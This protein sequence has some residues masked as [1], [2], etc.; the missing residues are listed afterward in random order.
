MN[1]LLVEDER[2]QRV[3]LAS[4]IKSNFIDVRIY[5]AASQA[6]AIK[7]INE[8]DIH[9]FFIDIQ[10]KDSSGLELA[11]KNKAIQATCFNWNRICNRRAYTHYRSI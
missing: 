5:E 4:I 1:I 6:E 9:L 8:K 11:K 7:I 3:A 2:I 10:L